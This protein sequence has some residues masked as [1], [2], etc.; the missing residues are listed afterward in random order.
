L[1]HKPL[2]NGATAEAPSATSSANRP[3]AQSVGASGTAHPQIARGRSPVG[4]DGHPWWPRCL[5]FPHGEG[6][7]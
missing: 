2:E 3:D 6:T 4:T 5:I 1:G 7:P